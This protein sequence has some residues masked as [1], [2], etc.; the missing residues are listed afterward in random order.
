MT[1]LEEIRELEDKTAFSECRVL[2]LGIITAGAGTTAILADLGADVIKIEGPK[3]IDPF[4]RWDGPLPD[5]FEKDLPPY[6]CM[7]NR[8]K[9]NLLMD[10]KSEEAR[11]VFLDMVQKSDVVVENFRRGVLEGWGLGYE[12]LKA[13]NPNIILASISSQGE[14]GPDSNYV[15]FGSTL[16]AMGGL[17]SITGYADGPPVITGVEFNY[18]DQVVAIFAASMIATAWHN[19]QRGLGG[20][21]LDLSQREL[22]AFLCGEALYQKESKPVGNSQRGLVLQDC[23]KAKDEQWVAISVREEDVNSLGQIGC[24]A[25]KEDLAAWVS[26]RHG[27][28]VVEL[29]KQADIPAAIAAK[30]ADIMS[31]HNQSWARALSRDTEGKLVKGSLFEGVD[32]QHGAQ[33]PAGLPGNATERI[34]H[35]VLGLEGDALAQTIKRLGL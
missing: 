5:G 2:D 15:S 22:T 4:R 32:T 29:L 20:A 16:E 1:T 28:E 12:T 33:Q 31:S 7:T 18:P 13:V 27:R 17:A 14:Y 26:M 34:L 3:Y 11:S 24:Q 35:D 10:L 30:G 23:F 21:H 25:S 8:G 9:R 6:F 19:R